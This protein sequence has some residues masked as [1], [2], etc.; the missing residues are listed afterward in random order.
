MAKNWVKPLFQM[1]R[2]ESA[3]THYFLN[4]VMRITTFEGRRGGL[5]PPSV[6]SAT[7]YIDAPNGI[8]ETTEPET[9]QDLRLL[10]G[11]PLQLTLDEQLT[12]VNH[13]RIFNG[14]ITSVESV[15]REQSYTVICQLSTRAVYL[16][17]EITLPA[18]TPAENAED[19]IN[20]VVQLT[21]SPDSLTLSTAISSYQC[22][23]LSRDITA[24]AQRMIRQIADTC[25]AA[26]W[27]NLYVDSADDQSA[28]TLWLTDLAGDARGFKFSTHPIE[29]I[30]P[31]L[32]VTATEFRDGAGTL[33]KERDL[34]ANVLQTLRL[35]TQSSASATQA[36][37]AYW[38]A[39]YSEPVA[40]ILECQFKP[41]EDLSEA[42]C[43]VDSLVGQATA[44][45]LRPGIQ[46]NL[47]YGVG[48]DRVTVAN[49]IEGVEWN[50]NPLDSVLGRPDITVRIWLLPNVFLASTRWVLGQSELGVDTGFTGEAA[51]QNDDYEWPAGAAVAASAFNRFLVQQS[52]IYW[53]DAILP[54]GVDG[55]LLVR[56]VGSEYELLI[57]DGG[58]QSRAITGV[59]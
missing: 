33:H 51:P 39:R 47:V 30:D 27:G 18:A 57:H 50:I 40:A 56:P 55:Q 23:A 20:R 34:T 21:G 31:R 37:S 52:P 16:N 17:E 9:I 6:G 58:W 54:M 15:R 4:R 38:L 41:N 10:V 53:E 36:L 29:S 25:A 22:V 32:Q 14:I 45:V 28:S 12:G 44:D 49:R 24:N 2:S 13:G 26:W 48:A 5:A 19:R 43:W 8:V 59:T 3:T 46:C 35:T 11:R 42:G 7:I 1:R